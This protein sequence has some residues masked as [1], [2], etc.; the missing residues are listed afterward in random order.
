MT[1]HCEICGGLEI[2][3]YGVNMKSKHVECEKVKALQ[4]IANALEGLSN[5]LEEFEHKLELG[6]YTPVS[7]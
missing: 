4:R 7:K 3:M 5:K 1:E 6:A 2:S